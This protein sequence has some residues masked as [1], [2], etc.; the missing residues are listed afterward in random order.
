MSCNGTYPVAQLRLVYPMKTLLPTAVFH[1]TELAFHRTSASQRLP[2][3]NLP[4]VAMQQWTEHAKSF[5]A[6]KQCNVQI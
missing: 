6:A 3:P 5:S 1:L 4:R 2:K